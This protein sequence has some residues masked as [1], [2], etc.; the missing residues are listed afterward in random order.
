MYHEI[1]VVWWMSS[2]FHLV[3]SIYGTRVPWK[4]KFEILWWWGQGQMAPSVIGLRTSYPL[5]KTQ[6]KC[7]SPLCNINQE[8]INELYWETGGTKLHKIQLCSGRA[9]MAEEAAQRSSWL[10]FR[11]IFPALALSLSLKTWRLSHLPWILLHLNSLLLFE[12][13][14]FTLYCCLF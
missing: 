13:T 5:F 9:L 11:G 8:P 14:L 6:I 12:H 1:K 7:P 4:L 10:S 2:S 3:S